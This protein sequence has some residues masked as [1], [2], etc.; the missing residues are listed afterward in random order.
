MELV[1][2]SVRNLTFYVSYV[3][4]IFAKPIVF[5]IDILEYFNMLYA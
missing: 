2:Y 1:C 5:S 3:F 4:T